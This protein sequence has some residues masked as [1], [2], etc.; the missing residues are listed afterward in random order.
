MT[1]NRTLHGRPRPE[2]LFAHP[3]YQFGRAF[4]RRGTGLPFREVRSLE[5]LTAEVATAEVL[6]VSGLWRNALIAHAPKLAL[7]QSVSAGINQYDQAA[8]AAAGIRL[9]NASGV[10][11]IAVAEHAFALMLALTRHVHH[12]RDNQAL[13]HWRPMIGEPATRESE[14]A[15][16]TLLVVGLGPIGERIARLAKAFDMT[17]IG[18]RRRPEEGSNAADRVVGLTDLG[19]ALAAADVV[20]LACPLTPE[21]EHLIDAAALAQMKPTAL[22]INVARGKVVDEPALVDALQGAKIAAAG[23][24]V[25][26]EEPLAAA[27][28]LWAMPNVLI[29][30]HTAGETQAY[31]E[32]II[33]LMLENIGR[34]QAGSPDLANQIV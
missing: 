34:L 19:T 26:A 30:P 6:V 17:V 32:R 3:A 24:D 8:F 13:R 28:P 9:A 1:S 20:V 10:N 33:D 22:L 23:L 16:K 15:G 12:A 4:E 14:L 11:A 21:T 7:L 18:A 2:I 29:T 25:T 27:S 5:A 31:E